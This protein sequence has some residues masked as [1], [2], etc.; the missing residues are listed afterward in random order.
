MQI[1]IINENNESFF[2]TLIG[3]FWRKRENNQLYAGVI[4]GEGNAVSAAVFEAAESGLALLFVATD[5][6][7]RRKGYAG[8]LIR[9]IAK[10]LPSYGIGRMDCVVYLGRDKENREER[11]MEKIRRNFLIKNGFF[12]HRLPAERRIY[13]MGDIFR[14]NVPMEEPEGIVVKKPS[15]LTEE[16][17]IQISQLGSVAEEAGVYMVPEN[18]V[19][20][21][22]N[23]GGVLFEG[24][25]AMAMLS[26][27]PLLDGVQL[28]SMFLR[29]NRVELIQYLMDRAIRQIEKDYGPEA[30]LYV[31]IVG[32]KVLDYL[33][34]SLKKIGLEPLEVFDTYM[35][36]RE[37][38]R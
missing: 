4:D 2:D 20:D 18:F 36:V 16:E 24:N 14:T 8:F 31:D 6:V 11:E 19:S 37:G 35:A 5:P 27:W 12:L 22:N 21:Q 30:R 34:G 3:E 29:N 26:A 9:E 25:K 15:E 7:R 38:N 23:Y 1:T 32:Q 10:R 33:K 13:S 17:L 28:D